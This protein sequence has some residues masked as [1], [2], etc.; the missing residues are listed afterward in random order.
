M[1]TQDNIKSKFFNNESDSDSDNE[2]ESNT[3]SNNI[4]NTKRVKSRKAIKAEIALAKQQE[5]D[6]IKLQKKQ[7]K[8]KKKEEEKEEKEK[9]EYS[10][11]DEE[12]EDEEYE[13]EEDKDDNDSDKDSEKRKSNRK[14][15][16]NNFNS[17]NN[18][19]GFDGFEETNLLEIHIK[20]INRNS[21]KRTTTVE[22]I[23]EKLL[24]D[25]QNVNKFLTKMRNAISASVSLKNVKE[26]NETKK[27][28]V[29]SGSNT[30]SMVPLIMEFVDCGEDNIKIH[31]F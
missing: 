24:E 9:K 12:Y 25:K 15:K 11:E 8:N 26:N 1:S 10:E 17:F 16:F 7:M 4:D 29:A 31:K 22:G 18:I 20:V 5:L 27:I 19:N 13:D 30:D 28:I 14:I 23:P 21:R 2:A 3:K 6:R